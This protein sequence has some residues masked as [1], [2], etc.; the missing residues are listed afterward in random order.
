MDNNL[1]HKINSYLSFELNNESFALNV[2]NVINILEMCKI[3]EIPKSPEYMKGVINLRGMVLPVIDMGI[4]LGTEKIKISTNTCILVLELN[5]DKEIIKIGA[6]V[7]A[8]SEVL[9]IE[10]KELLD[11]PTIGTKYKSEFIT[12]LIKKDEKFI[13]VLDINKI[14]SQNEIVELIEVHE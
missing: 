4:K 9:E 6:I 8:V 14:F 13:M 2:R 3:T 10:P 1:K 5:I 11:P 12:S 7:D